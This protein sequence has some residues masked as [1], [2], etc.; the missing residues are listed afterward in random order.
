MR[1]SMEWGRG[2][3]PLFNIRL[4]Y[5][6]RLSYGRRDGYGTIE[7][8]RHQYSRSC[9]MLAL[10]EDHVGNASNRPYTTDRARCFSGLSC[11]I[12]ELPR[13]GGRARCFT[14]LSCRIPVLAHADR[15]RE[16]PICDD[17]RCRR[18]RWCQDKVPVSCFPFF[19]SFCSRP[20][21]PH[22]HVWSAISYN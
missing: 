3:S 12:P 16:T 14:G 2:P 8:H 6:I 21:P 20:L 19:R 18:A 7:L 13:P 5:H 10:H 22:H 17:I 11:N 9:K 15:L 4:S 1:V